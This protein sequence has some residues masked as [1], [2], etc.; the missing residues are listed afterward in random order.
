ML[1]QHKGKKAPATPSHLIALY[2][3]F[4]P[5]PRHSVHTANALVGTCKM[6]DDAMSVVS[7]DLKVKGVTGV[8][9]ADSSI[10]PT[11]PGGQT[12]TPTVMVAVRAA[13]MIATGEGAGQ[14]SV[15]EDL[16]G[17]GKVMVGV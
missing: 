8:R 2:F 12:G 3:P 5:N 16:K 1:Q 10:F 4:S 6:G 15:K 7:S 17:K 14:G 9:V 11:I 13:E